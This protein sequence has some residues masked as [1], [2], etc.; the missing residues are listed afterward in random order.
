MQLIGRVSEAARIAIRTPTLAN[1]VRAEAYR[2]V[3]RGRVRSRVRNKNSAVSRKRRRRN[4]LSHHA[5]LFHYLW[6]RIVHNLLGRLGDRRYGLLIQ[7]RHRKRQ[8]NNG[9]SKKLPDR[10][11]IVHQHGRRKR[12]GKPK[13]AHDTTASELLVCPARVA[14]HF[15]AQDEKMC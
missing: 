7:L 13:T 3:L 6:S 8:R 11:R 14:R 10:Q 15:Q 2:H 4:L 1:Q 12:H 9:L 5:F